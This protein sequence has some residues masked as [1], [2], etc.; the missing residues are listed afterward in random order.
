MRLCRGKSLI[1]GVCAGIAE[2]LDMDAL[3][4][5]VFAVLLLV[6]TCGLAGIA[7]LVMWAAL[8]PKPVTEPRLLEVSPHEVS[9]ETYGPL[10]CDAA[11]GMGVVSGDRASEGAGAPPPGDGAGAGGMAGGAGTRSAASAGSAAAAREAAA[12]YTKVG[13]LPPTP[14]VVS[15]WDA[16]QVPKGVPVVGVPTPGSPA[17]HWEA[18]PAESVVPFTE[19]R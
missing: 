4:V 12:L 1:G 15:A 11:C 13:H 2:R 17:G 16:L 6:S 18:A 10:S 3:A 14:P 8:P 9:S 19:G 7:Y 5:R